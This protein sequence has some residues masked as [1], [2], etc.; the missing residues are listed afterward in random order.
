L[1]GDLVEKLLLETDYGIQEEIHKKLEEDIMN[2]LMSSMFGD[3]NI[4]TSNESLTLQK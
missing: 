1:G 2:L 4:S 3:V